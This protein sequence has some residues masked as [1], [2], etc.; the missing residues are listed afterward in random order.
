MFDG[1]HKALASWLRNDREL[2]FKVYLNMTREQATGLINSIQS[3]I[4]KLPLT[5]FELASKLSKEYADKLSIYESTRSADACSEA[6]F[7][8]SL[9]ASER[10]TAKKEIE[11]AV[12]QEIADDPTLLMSEIVE[13]RGRKLDLDWR[14]T[15]TAF[16][17]KLLKE[18]AH[19]T[20]LP[21]RFAGGEMQAAR[22]RERQNIIACLNVL[23]EKVYQD[24]DS[25][26]SS[27]Q[28]E[29]AKRMS[30]QSALRY[31]AALITKIVINRVPPNESSLVFVE[32]TPDSNQFALISD[33]IERLVNHSV[34]TAGTT[35]PGMS[36]VL[37]SLQKNQGVDEAMV[38]LGL[39]PAYCVGM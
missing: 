10:P 9:P 29:R 30:Y 31:V 34:W 37:D 5:P 27:Q 36:A 28:L 32:R 18:L 20:P 16:Q 4:K 6:D 3:K 25:T 1:Q 14:I 15:E 19:T 2:V 38:H 33:A 22:I 12:L 39:T 26:S 24:L 21:N 35:E 23:Y 11:S 7:V 17:N 13:M 8:N